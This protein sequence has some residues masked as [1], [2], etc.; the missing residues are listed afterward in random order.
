MYL[1]HELWNRTQDRDLLESFYPSLRQYYLFMAGSA[2]SST[3]RELKSNLLRTW[4]YCSYNSAGWD[5]YP[6]QVYTLQEGDPSK[7]TCVAITAH[8]TRSAK[9]LMAAADA[10]TITEDRAIYESD[11]EVFT[12]ALQ[13]HAWDGESG[14]FS[15]VLHDEDG[16]PKEH[17]RHES[18]LNFNM[19][20]DGVMP[21][22]AG[23]CTPEQEALMLKRLVDPDR[24]WTRIGLSTVDQ[25]APYY[26]KEGYWNG[27]VW[28]PYQW[29]FWKTALD[30][31]R[32]DFANQIGNNALDLWKTEVEASYYCFEHFLIESGRGA[33]W[34]QFG[35][36]SSP[37]LSWFSAYH[38]PGRLTTGLDIWVEEQ[39][40]ANHYRSFTG[41]LRL[42]SSP[43]TVTVL[44][45]MQPG[46]QYSVLWNGQRIKKKEINPGS[47]QIE[48]PFESQKGHL[49]VVMDEAGL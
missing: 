11:I 23:I 42:T 32:G 13:R 41:S 38:R 47:F 4:E 26:R 9:I 24:F 5:D 33:G 27:A 49:E 2:G 31:G 16:Y 17:L 6:A 22:V 1:F 45:N 3:T 20:L 15:Y 34:H 43:R 37:V 35:G 7:T 21:L 40:F 10:L 28:M 36:L 12:E 30:L 46:P 14:Y 19:G 8:L 25:S 44:V 18:D 39:C 48:L 29:F